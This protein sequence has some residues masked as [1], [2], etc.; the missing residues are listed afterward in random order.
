MTNAGSDGQRVVAGLID[1]AHA[2]SCK[3]DLAS[4]RQ[5]VVAGLELHL[6]CVAEG[7][8][9]G[10]HEVVGDTHERAGDR[11]VHRRFHRHPIQ[12]P[13]AG[14]EQ[15]VGRVQTGL[16]LTRQHAAAVPVEVA[17]HLEV[18]GSGEHQLARSSIQSAERT[19]TAQK[20]L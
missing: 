2:G 5:R 18:D 11:H 7:G 17:A 15:D 10:E 8:R 9:P 20:V 3:H 1:V 16:L 14:G 6:C 19:G 4:G 13:A 12:R